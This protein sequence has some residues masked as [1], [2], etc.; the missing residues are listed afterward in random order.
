MSF[1][2][3]LISLAVFCGLFAVMAG[4]FGNGHPAFESLGIFRLHVGI[5][6]AVLWPVAWVFKLRGMARVS[7]WGAIAA[8]VGLVT[9]LVPPVG[10]DE[11]DLVGYQHNLRFD[12]PD[13]D[14][15]VAAIRET[16]PDFITLQEVSGENSQVLDELRATY[17]H[18]LSCEFATIGGVAIL[19]R[20]QPFGDPVCHRGRGLAWMEVQTSDGTVTIATAHLP[21]PWPYEQ[22]RQVAVYEEL[23]PQM[24]GRVIWAG[25]FNNVGW[26]SSVKRLANASRTQVVRGLR[27]TFHKLPIW[28][29]LPIDQVLVSESLRASVTRLEKYGSDHNALEVRVRFR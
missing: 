28:P 15:V 8:G 3:S 18:Q 6:L 9:T 24:P 4:F 2:R 16:D 21:W 17:P 12:N 22:A 1:L 20:L 7:F 25:D 27:P 5:G 26:S 29:G 23:A 19:S 14:A 10:I 11:P 13:L